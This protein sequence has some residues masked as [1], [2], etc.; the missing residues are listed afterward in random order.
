MNRHPTGRIQK[1]LDDTGPTAVSRSQLANTVRACSGRPVATTSATFF[2]DTGEGTFV[3]AS[4]EAG[5]V[6]KRLGRGAAFGD[7][8]EDGDLDVAIDEHARA[9]HVSLQRDHRQR[10]LAPAPPG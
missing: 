4:K 2:L 10:P 6:E 3:A 8:D 9:P 7:V 5:L 1:R